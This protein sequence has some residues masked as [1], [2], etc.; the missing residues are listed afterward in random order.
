M[1]IKEQELEQFILLKIL[2]NHK[3]DQKIVRIGKIKIK[4][5]KEKELKLLIFKENDD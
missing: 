1:K 3:I 2:L 4:I 5:V